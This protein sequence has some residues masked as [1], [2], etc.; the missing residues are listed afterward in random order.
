MKENYEDTWGYYHF[1]RYV[2][3]RGTSHFSV[4]ILLCNGVGTTVLVENNHKLL[5]YVI[6]L[7][8]RYTQFREV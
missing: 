3:Y 5:L 2:H 6:T 4:F 8:I 7:I 1:L